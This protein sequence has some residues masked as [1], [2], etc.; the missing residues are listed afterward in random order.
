MNWLLRFFRVGWWGS[1][2]TV[3][4]PTPDERTFIVESETRAFIVEHE[5]RSFTV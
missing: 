4:P 1:A 3:I 2:A 5:D